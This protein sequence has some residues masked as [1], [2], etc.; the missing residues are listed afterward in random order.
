MQD[1]VLAI[2]VVGIITMFLLIDALDQLFGW[3]KQ[4]F[5]K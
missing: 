1:F 2:P 4:R 3:I 5:F